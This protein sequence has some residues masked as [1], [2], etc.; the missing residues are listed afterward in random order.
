MNLP[1][2]NI[3]LTRRNFIKKTSLFGT[4]IYINS[5]K[6]FQVKKFQSSAD[7]LKMKYRILG[8]SGLK[9]SEVGLGTW[10]APNENVL[11]YALDKG[12]NY[13]DTAPEYKNG[14]EERMVGKAVKNRR[15]KA[16]IATKIFTNHEQVQLLEAGD[17]FFQ[18]PAVI[19]ECDLV[20][21]VETSVIH[22]A[23]ALNVPVISL[24]R[25]KNPEW[26]PYGKRESSIIFA[27][28]R[29][30]WVKNIMVK[31][32]VSKVKDSGFLIK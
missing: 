15:E 6:Y 20:I 10:E 29:R 16:I 24:M 5:G 31:E 18:L 11:S 25:T 17:N 2:N 8:R 28:D 1:K 12:I 26:I 27:R 23:T 30:S 13:I 3:K 21:S 14:E 22:L 32:V 9:V 4:G 7:D 19:K